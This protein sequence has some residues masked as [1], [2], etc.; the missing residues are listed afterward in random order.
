MSGGYTV[1]VPP[2]DLAPRYEPVREAC[3]RPHD[4][5]LPGTVGFLQV[6]R[7]PCPSPTCTPRDER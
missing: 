3:R 7:C 1:G 4:A 6:R 5:P 2:L